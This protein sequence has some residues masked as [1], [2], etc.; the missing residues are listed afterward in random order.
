MAQADFI[1]KNGAVI[2]NGLTATSTSTTTGALIV[3]GGIATSG[4]STFGGDLNIVSNTSSTNSTT[5]ALTILG[6]LGVFGDVN[7]GTNLKV[8]GVDLMTFD[9]HIHYVSDSTGNDNNDGHRLQS[10]FRTVK[11]AIEQAQAGDTVY[12]EAGT[13]QE[14]FPITVPAGVSIR[15]AGLREVY[16]YPTTATNTQTAFLLNGETTISDFTVGGFYK[17]GYAFKFA[18]GAKITTRS[19]Y[20]E[21][22]SVITRGSNPQP[23]DPYGYDSNDAGG[24][25][26]LDGANVDSTSLEAAFLFNEATFITPSSTAVHIKNGT[27]VELLNGF[28]YFADKA[29]VGESGTTGWGDQGRTRLRLANSTGTFTVGHSLHYVGSTG[30]LLATGVIDEVTPEYIYLQGKASGFVEAQD[31][32]GKT[33]NVYGNTVISS[34]E[35]KFGTGAAYFSTDGDLLDIVSDADMQYGFSSYTLESWVHLTQNGRKQYILNKGSIPSTTFGLYIGADNKLTGQHGTTLFT[36]TNVLNTGTWYHI[37]MSRDINNVNRLFINGNLEATVTATS[38]ISNADS[39]TIGG[40]AGTPNLSLRGYLDEVRVSTTPRY[41]GSFTPPTSAYAS[42][43]STTVLLHCDG[44]NLSTGFTDDGLGSQ[45]VFSTTGTY[46]AAV[47]ASA[48]QISLADYRQFGGELR[49]IGSAACYGNYGI[50]ADGEG[51]DFKAIAFNMSYVGSGKD[52]TND[53]ALAVQANEIVR[54]N[55]AKVYFQTVDHIGDFRVGPEF[56]INQRTGNV[57]FGT[58]NFRLGPL[59]SL[60]ISDGVNTSVLQPTSIQVGQLLFSGNRVQTIS[61]NLTIDPAGTLTTIES[62]LQVNGALNFTGQIRATSV[63]NSTST[64]T[65]ALVVSGG[66]GLAKDL[67][68]GGNATVVGDLVVKGK[69]TVVNSTQTSIADP[70]LD[71]GIAP[72]GADLTVDDNFDRGLLL[73]YNTGTG[74]TSYTRTFL[75]MDNNTETLIY[76]TRVITGPAGEYVP[77]FINSGFWGAA[78]F[79]SL[80]LADTTPGGTLNSGALQVAGGASFAG[81]VYANTYYDSTGLIL[82]TATIGQYVVT[83]ALSGEDISVSSIPVTPGR[84]VVTINNTS[85][86]QSVTRRGSTTTYALTFAN[87][88]ESTGTAS[89]ALVVSGGVGVGGNLWATNLYS[90]GSLVVTQATIGSLGVTAINA[91][92]D[93]AVSSSTGVVVIWNTSTLDTVA[94]RGST[95]TAAI[96]IV[97]TTSSTSTNSG[98][99]TVSGGVGVGGN[100]YAANIYSNGIQV[101][102]TETD[103]LESVTMRGAT[104]P[105]AVTFSNTSQA[106]ISG[107]S[108]AVGITGGLYVGKKLYV[109]EYATFMS[110]PIVGAIDSRSALTV[111]GTN[112]LQSW[113]DPEGGILDLLWTGTGGVGYFQLLPSSGQTIAVGANDVVKIYGGA[114]GNNFVGINTATPTAQLEVGGDIKAA[115]IYSNGSLVITNA[116]LGSYGVTSIQGGSGISVNTSTGAVTVTSTDTLQ[117]VTDR[118]N[119]TTNSILISNTNVST[120]TTTGALVVTGGVGISG[121]ATIQTALIAGVLRGGTTALAVF[122]NP[123]DSSSTTDGSVTIAGGLGVNKRLYAGELYD[124]G[125]RVVTNVNPN[126]GPGITITDE[127]SVGTSTSFTIN[128]AGVIAA[129]GTQ[130]LGVSS[131]TGIVTFT[132]LGVQTLTA[133][134]DT[135]VSRSTGTVVVWNTSTLQSITN[136]GS[137][138]TNAINI[139]NATDSNTW[140]GGALT[141][142]GGVGIAKNLIVGGNAAIYGNLQVLGTQTYV[143]STQTVVVDP[144]LSIGAGVDNTNLGVNDGFDRGVLLHY[145]TTATINNSFDNHSFLGM[146]NATKKLVYKTNIYPGGVQEFPPLFANTGTWGSAQF[147]SLNLVDTTSATNTV[148]G[149]LT[150]SGGVGIGGDLYVGN[151]IYSSGLEVLTTSSLGSGGV[152]VSQIFAGTDTAVS[153]NFGAITIWSTATLQSLTQRGS[154]TNQII[155]FT[156]TTTAIS[157]TT[158]AVQISGGLSVGRDLWVEGAIYGA[159]S[160]IEN[161]AAAG[162]SPGTNQWIRCLT[163]ALPNVGDSITFKMK[164]VVKASASPTFSDNMDNDVLWISY[165]KDSPTT[166]LGSIYWVSESSE[167]GISNLLANHTLTFNATT[168]QFEYWRRSTIAG[169]RIWTLIQEEIPAN[170]AYQFVAPTIVRDG[171]WAAS[172]TSLGSVATVDDIDVIQYEDLTITGTLAHS[173]TLANLNNTTSANTLGLSAGAITSGVTKTVNIATGGL[174]GSTSDVNIGSANTGTLGRLTVASTLTTF[175][176]TVAATNTQTAAVVIAGGLAVG[177]NLVVG[178]GATTRGIIDANV[179]ASGSFAASGDAQAGVYV[180]RALS[181]STAATVLT[182]NNSAA[183]TN[184][185]VILPDNSSYM[186]KIFVTA[187]STTTNDEGAW[188]FNGSISR[189][190]GAGTTVLRM[191]NKTKIWASQAYDVDLAADTVNGGLS[192]RAI[193]INSSST[194]FVAKVETV[195]VST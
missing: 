191:S 1:V 36:S 5:G 174:T 112:Q 103:T 169:G 76:K 139:T 62:D 53:P 38:S 135:S 2:L 37:M 188:E 56:R 181:T 175:A 126:A 43:I 190:A 13:Y 179:V 96:N 79:G 49:C 173:G 77:Q 189:Y 159:P 99:L 73:H 61:G 12:I 35:R 78:K 34:F 121:Q 165:V 171:T 132:N 168:G 69:T 24:G 91:G 178:T 124:S 52:F 25:A 156:N 176:S 157:T 145:S 153:S 46:T 9:D 170:P 66:I 134:T 54:L 130:F 152:G 166:V 146:D 111:N 15:G 86:L 44:A 105:Y 70:I 138:T 27:R 63:E 158:G 147:G 183:S 88:T 163:W 48:Q 8:R 72:D 195:E 161:S 4:R 20:V 129:V 42:D 29:I 117:T 21:R 151:K 155:Y 116:T 71:L 177:E 50:Y 187:K 28:S 164:S 75:G 92:T 80:S 192:V 102:T 41:T 144:V 16:V 106:T 10:A 150:V 98:A 82:S 149:A 85:T 184:N 84:G 162:V 3:Q 33:I 118:G 6:G 172:V 90:N 108:K 60:T 51:I 194:R 100:I 31:R 40:Y 87:Q 89:G 45:N 160:F 180:L 65:G 113:F 57:D 101:L 148:S 182:T 185:Q 125:N 122:E 14:E 68:V 64:T 193:G 58:A 104:T 19:P 123:T 115:N 154:S 32:T 23:G 22:F 7:I 30:T 137:T 141:V 133:G 107:S 47:V 186:F 55:G 11:R 93:T 136:R 81:A 127:V 128:N 167:A 120:S 140:T 131:A 83:Q 74:T 95:T 94:N 119:S 143:N 142:G 17:P 97:N 39:L 67:W 18:P 114:P 26:Y 59:S 110:S 109:N